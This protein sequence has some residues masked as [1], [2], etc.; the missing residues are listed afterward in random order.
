MALPPN[1]NNSSPRLGDYKDPFEDP[2]IW[3]ILSNATMESPDQFFHLG[4]W[5]SKLEIHG[6]LGLFSHAVLETVDST[7]IDEEFLNRDLQAFEFI[8]ASNEIV[9]QFLIQY[10]IQQKMAGFTMLKDPLS[11]FYDA[12]RRRRTKKLQ[13]EDLRKYYG[14]PMDSAANELNVC[15]SVMKKLI[16][17]FNIKRWPHRKIKSFKRRIAALQP[18]LRSNDE[19]ERRKA[20][21]EIQLL[22]HKITT[23]CAGNGEG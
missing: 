6:R 17:K 7:Q 14:I 8:E 22:Q 21:Q 13:P 20:L 23:M 1:N 10:C 3:D 9:K 12:L 19:E 4:V 16:H 15:G 5:I 18:L 2:N 11:G